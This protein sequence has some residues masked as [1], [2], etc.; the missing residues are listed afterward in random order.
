M[1]LSKPAQPV[2]R[3][4]SRKDDYHGQNQSV[5]KT[6]HAAS[7]HLN[8][9]ALSRF[10]AKKTGC[11]SAFI[12]AP[13]A[14]AIRPTAR[15]STTQSYCLSYS[16]CMPAGFICRWPARPDKQRLYPIIKQLAN[17]KQLIFI[18]VIDPIHPM[19][20]TC[21]PGARSG[22]GS[23]IVPAGRTIGNHGRLW[24]RSICG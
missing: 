22:S 21:G 2:C 19:V 4:I 14:T 9:L 18:G 24:L 20:E 23:G 5:R 3:S 15:T 17:A 11:G 10:T 12:P 13:E 1:E 16:G 8:N 6:P 7:S